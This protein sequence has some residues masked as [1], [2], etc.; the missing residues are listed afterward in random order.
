MFNYADGNHA[1]ALR[2]PE[3]WWPIEQDYFID[4]YQSRID[5]ALPP[6]VDSSWRRC[7]DFARTTLKGRGRAIPGG[8]ATVLTAPLD[9]RG[10]LASVTVLALAIDVV[11]GLM[12]LSLER[13]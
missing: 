10:R 3:T 13:P 8:A 1:V 7:A 12:S 2:H 11:I 6:R 4:D 5:G 9:A